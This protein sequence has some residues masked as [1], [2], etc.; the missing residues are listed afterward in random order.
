M[1][2]PK[3]VGCILDES[4][5]VIG[6]CV[7]QRWYR[8]G[9]RAK[10]S[11]IVHTCRKMVAMAARRL[12]MQCSRQ[13]A[14][15]RQ[16]WS[17]PRQAGLCGERHDDRRNRTRIPLSLTY[18]CCCCCCCSWRSNPAI[19]LPT[20]TSLASSDFILLGLLTYVTGRKGVT[21]PSLKPPHLKC[22]HPTLWW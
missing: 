3:R 19:N 6:K 1:F 14:I 11:L 4:I 7:R 5:S 18:T 2:M 13:W 17:I 8:R 20:L 12:T 10:Y 9:V 22:T 16:V 15:M 21:W